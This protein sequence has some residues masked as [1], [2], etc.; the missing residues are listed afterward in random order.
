[1]CRKFQDPLRDYVLMEEEGLKGQQIDNIIKTE[2]ISPSG[3][4]ATIS[5]VE[6]SGALGRCGEGT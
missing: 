2:S 1:M 6:P 3:C 5:L 4:T